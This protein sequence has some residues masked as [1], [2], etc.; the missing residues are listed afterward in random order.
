MFATRVTERL[1]RCILS[2]ASR[3]ALRRDRGASEMGGQ[4]GT[5]LFQQGV[6]RFPPHTNDIPVL[7]TVNALSM[8]LLCTTMRQNWHRIRRKN[9]LPRRLT[10]SSPRCSFL[11]S[12]TLNVYVP[13]SLSFRSWISDPNVAINYSCLRCGW[14]RLPFSC[15]SVA[16]NL[17]ANGYM[18]RHSS[19]ATTEVCDKAP[20]SSP[21]T[22]AVPLS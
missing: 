5:G 6:P 22:D 13:I 3:R 9:I 4:V 18:Q 15:H 17:N 12:V 2:N 1:R 21:D 20:T 8:G 14:P 7:Y 10:S 19:I 16:A 11:R